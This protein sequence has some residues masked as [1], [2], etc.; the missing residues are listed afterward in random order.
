MKCCWKGKID[1]NSD[2]EEKKEQNKR[3]GKGRILFDAETGV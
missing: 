2:A 1:K 3:Q